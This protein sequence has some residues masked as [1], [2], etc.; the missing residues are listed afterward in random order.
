MT[1]LDGLLQRLDRIRLVHLVLAALLARVAWILVCPNAPY[2]DQSVYHYEAEMLAQGRGYIDLDGNPTNFYP[3]GYPALLGA[4]Y[5]IFGARYVV[6]Y[7]LNLVL[8]VVAITGAYRLGELL[9]GARAGKLAAL[10]IAVHPTF[11]LLTT[12]MAS[13]N[14][15]CAALPWALWLLARLSREPRAS[16]LAPAAGVAV[17]LM[18]YVRPPALLLLSCPAVFGLLARKPVRARA[19]QWVTDSLVAGVVALAVLAPWGL[20]NKRDFDRFSFTSFNAGINLYLGNS[21]GSNGEWQEEVPLETEDLPQPQSNVVFS[22]LA[23]EYIVTHPGRYV[24]LSFN[25]LFHT[26]RSDTIA[27][28]WDRVG[29]TRRLG[30]RAIVPLKIVCSLFH[31]ALLL[32]LAATLWRVGRKHLTD[33]DRQLAWVAALTAAPFILIVGGN[34]YMLPLMTLVCVWTASVARPRS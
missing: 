28:V 20:R 19:R 29:I 2:S 22:K 26:M 17:A 9:F 24:A 25:R 5:A 23:R 13:E 4:S 10:L 16:W 32:G 30:K 18:T 11:I 8:A 34:R 3:V 14:P 21:P 27:P 33:A 7:G 12:A 6:A 1:R 15:F 31:W